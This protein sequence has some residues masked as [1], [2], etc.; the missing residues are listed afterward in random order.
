MAGPAQ[1]AGALG[2]RGVPQGGG[3]GA[4]AG[5]GEGTVRGAE[6]ATADVHDHSSE[7]RAEGCRGPGRRHGGAPVQQL[8]ALRANTTQLL[9]SGES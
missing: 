9:E 2:R 3:V 4:E 1:P 8:R 7:R 6:I 5:A